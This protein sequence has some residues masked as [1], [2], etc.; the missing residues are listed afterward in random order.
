MLIR[1]TSVILALVL[2]VLAADFSG[3]WKLNTAKSKYTGMPKPKEMTVVY[4]PQGSGWAYEAKGTTG[5]G[6]PISTS[7]VYVKDGEDIKIAGSS[8]G[9]T[10]VLRNA[11][12]DVATGVFKRGGKVIGQVKRTFS[13][14]GKTM[15]I[16]GNSVLPDGK[17]VTYTSVYEKQ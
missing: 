6:Q 5:E 10:L 11:Q 4:T 3:T 1:L 16:A 14:A 7:F 2:P 13:D 17:P 8:L 12:G 9:D 15:I